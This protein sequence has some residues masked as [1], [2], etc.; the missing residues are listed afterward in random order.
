MLSVEASA[1][2]GAVDAD[3]PDQIKHVATGVVRGVM[4]DLSAQVKGSLLPASSV[5]ETLSSLTS[6]Q[7]VTW[8][9]RPWSK[10]RAEVLQESRTCSCSSHR[11]A[12]PTLGTG[13]LSGCRERAASRAHSRLEGE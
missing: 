5:S 11:G 9:T 10:V 2:A 1:I 7:R 12:A 13:R 6:T 8:N 3:M 4:P